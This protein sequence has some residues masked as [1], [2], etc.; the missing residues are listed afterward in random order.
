MAINLEKAPLETLYYYADNGKT[1][2]PFPLNELLPKIKADTLVY[3]D[4]IEWTNAKDVEELRGYFP[5]EEPKKPKSP[6]LVIVISVLLLALIGG[7]VLISHILDGEGEGKEKGKVTD[8]EIE[9]DTV[10]ITPTYEIA[11][12]PTTIDEGTSVIFKITTTNVENSTNLYWTTD[13]PEGVE[14]T[15]S[16]TDFNDGLTQG[17][18]PVNGNSA[19]LVR[20]I[21][22]DNLT[23][24]KFYEVFVIHLR[25]GSFS[26]RILATSNEISIQDTSQETPKGRIKNEPKV[27]YFK[28]L[29]GEVR[30]VLQ[31][32]V[33]DGECD[34]DDCSDESNI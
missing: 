24:G 15:P 5:E 9:G 1:V 14:N 25:E 34:C 32:S 20:P 17:K 4:G 18:I 27:E 22:K 7:G 16:S 19:T 26:G 23:E 33:N 31:T 21:M 2:G 13:A 6:L 3:R 10:S 8:T 29:R 12:N 30:E 11:G 28:C